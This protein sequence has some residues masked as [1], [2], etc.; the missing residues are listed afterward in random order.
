MKN[1]YFGDSLDFFEK[2][3]TN[4]KYISGNNLELLKAN[5]VFSA[6]TINRPIR[7]IL[8]DNENS[9][10]IIQNMFKTL[11]GQTEEGTISDARIIPD[12]YEEMNEK[13]LAIGRF[14]IDTKDWF[15]R[16][17]TGAFIAKLPDS[18][19][20]VYKY[21]FEENNQYSRDF[22]ISDDRDSAIVFNRPNIELFERQ[23]ASHFNINLNDQN[24]D[25]RVFVEDYTDEISNSETTTEEQKIEKSKNL[26]NRV[27][28]IRYYT[29]ID[30]TTY[31][32]KNGITVGTNTTRIPIDGSYCS[33]VFQIT[34]NVFNYYKNYLTNTDN[35]YSLEE[36][37]NISNCDGG[38]YS[39]YYNPT[40]EVNENNLYSKT[41]R[42]V[43]IKDSALNDTNNLIKLFSFTLTRQS[44][45]TTDN[46]NKFMISG[47]KSYL[48][49]IDRTK[50]TIKNIE[51]I[52][53]INK[54]VFENVN[55]NYNI[56][57][58]HLSKNET[59]TGNISIGKNTLGY[60]DSLNPELYSEAFKK[61]IGTNN[62]AI[63]S[64][65]M[66]DANQ[67][68][69]NIAIGFNTLKYIKNG[70]LNIEIGVGNGRTEGGQEFINIGSN[71][72]NLPSSAK[73]IGAGSK[74]II[75]G[76]DNLNN[77][78]GFS[79]KNVIFGINND[80]QTIA[81]DGNTIIGHD[82]KTVIS[83]SIHS[84]LGQNNTIIG[85]NN[86]VNNGVSIGNNTMLFGSNN[87]FRTTGENNHIFGNNNQ[88]K[89]NTSRNLN[90]YLF[91]QYN[92]LSGGDGN[93]LIGSLNKAEKDENKNNNSNFILGNSNTTK[94]STNAYLIGVSNK[95]TDGNNNYSIGSYLQNQDQ[96]D[97]IKIGGYSTNNIYSQV[98]PTTNC[99]NIGPINGIY[100]DDK[101]TT[102]WAIQVSAIKHTVDYSKS[103]PVFKPN[104]VVNAGVIQINNKYLE[105]KQTGTINYGW[106]ET[107][108]GRLVETAN[109]KNNSGSVLL[110]GINP[111]VN[112]YGNGISISSSVSDKNKT[113]SIFKQDAETLNISTHSSSGTYCNV[114]LSQYRFD[115][116]K[117]NTAI[118]LLSSDGT[119]SSF[120]NIYPN[121][122][123][124]YNLGKADKTWEDV[125]TR[126]IH[127]RTSDGY[128]ELNKSNTTET[129][130]FYGVLNL[131]AVKNLGYNVNSTKNELLVSADTLMNW[132]GGYATNASQS[133][134]ASNLQYCKNGEIL[135]S[136]GNQ[137]I[138]QK[139]GT[140]LILTTTGNDTK[141]NDAKSIK[142]KV[143]SSGD[144]SVAAGIIVAYGMD[145]TA[146]GNDVNATGTN[147]IYSHGNVYSKGN[148]T[149]EKNLSVT[150]NVNISGDVSG[151]SFTATSA[152]KYK[153]DIEPTKY[154]AIDEINKINIVDFYF[155]TDENNENPK[156]GFI[157]DDTEPIFSTPKKDAMDLYNCVGMLLKAVQELS[158][159]NKKLK[160]EIGS[161]KS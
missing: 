33:N 26:A 50:L 135:G 60:Y 66:S 112:T 128:T 153:K 42:F 78:V 104:F 19:S 110:T 100:T 154:N 125:F 2:N 76:R 23:L 124:S 34:N 72:L 97:S 35:Y 106:T 13:N 49:K 1:K 68:N 58:A 130:Q 69:S 137:I 22:Y 138:S 132:N 108:G 32:Y 45:D 6:R 85:T 9:Y 129:H 56:S 111:G 83:K 91:G 93:Y 92:T 43:L 149:T 105:L 155:K 101:N 123:N 145:T 90:T 46:D 51:L 24:N 96:T 28:K 157:A 134:N 95:D 38:S 122:T 147:A 142:L 55:D 29:E 127:L 118:T 31:D 152:R 18:L 161:L 126:N 70:R 144:T 80:I 63:G 120:Y 4:E 21:T 151:R 53:T 119:Y 115:I 37:I 30:N 113:G 114:V 10:Q 98:I 20:N 99:T 8:E 5:D 57:N 82:N 88:T 77:I 52:N 17:P 64:N 146:Q 75:I 14:N 25:V 131:S 74:N 48:K 156:V 94:N 160:R 44:D 109:Y 11:Y 7:Q 117:A 79:N 71:L 54:I 116:N 133:K 139:N 140:S 107:L 67:P 62:V 148:I 87:S 73:R 3:T 41:S 12:I 65:A 16:I 159:E 84:S 89:E 47:Q 15:L 40:L 59:N 86:E 136:Y 141:N 27:Q 81:G 39:V 158:E 143:H 102:S 103:L 61:T 121:A 36:V 150:G